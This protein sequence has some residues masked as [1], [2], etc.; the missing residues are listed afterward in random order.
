MLA[1]GWLLG[2]TVGI[3]TVVYALG[4]GPLV[5]L[6][7]QLMPARLHAASGWAAVHRE[8]APSVA[9]E[10]PA[11]PSMACARSGAA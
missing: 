10:S 1:V 3:G 8:P 2:G 4:I 11:T 9:P 5:Q 7:V 6:L